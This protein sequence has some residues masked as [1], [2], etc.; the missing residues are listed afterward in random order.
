[1]ASHFE[2]SGNGELSKKHELL[3]TVM[4][5][6]VRRGLKEKDRQGLQEA[7]SFYT[8]VGAYYENQKEA[9]DRAYWIDLMQGYRDR[10]RECIGNIDKMEGRHV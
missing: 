5:R 4:N 2:A 3:S 1:M 6:I 8:E 7:I 10:A 9:E